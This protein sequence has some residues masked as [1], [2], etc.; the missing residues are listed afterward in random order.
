MLKELLQ[1]LASDLKIDF[2]SLVKE[3]REGMLVTLSGQL[4]ISLKKRKALSFFSRRSEP[5][6]KREKR[7]FSPF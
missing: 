2:G 5:L 4:E 6:P 7:S 1:K 3:E